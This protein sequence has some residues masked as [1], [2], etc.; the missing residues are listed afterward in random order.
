MDRIESGVLRSGTNTIQLR[1]HSGEDNFVVRDVVVQ[2][3]R[4]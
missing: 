3:R 4:L 1:R 2:W